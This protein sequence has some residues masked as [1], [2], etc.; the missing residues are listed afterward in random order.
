MSYAEEIAFDLSEIASDMGTTCSIGGASDIACAASFTRRGEE[1][2]YAGKTAVI[3]LTL[4][5]LSSLIT[6][7]AI[8]SIVTYKSASYRVAAKRAA[9]TDT[10]FEFDCISSSERRK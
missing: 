10:H 8:G 1:I 7:P 4:I 3:Q 9:P 5:V 6:E 2:E